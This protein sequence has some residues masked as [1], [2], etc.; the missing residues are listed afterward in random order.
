[1]RK[2]DDDERAGERYG[3][4]KGGIGMFVFFMGR[5]SLDSN[6]N[7]PQCFRPVTSSGRPIVSRIPDEKLG[8]IKTRDGGNG[9]VF[10][11]AGHGAWDISHAPGTGMVLSELIEGRP[12]SAT[13]EALR[14]P[15]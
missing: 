10:I 6:V 5:F 12:T 7:D 9:G 3:G 4:S 15:V 13:I 14:L 2:G 8:G 11:A 1:V